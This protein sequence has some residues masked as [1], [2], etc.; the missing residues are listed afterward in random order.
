MK[1][2]MDCRYF[3]VNGSKCGRSQRKPDY[4]RGHPPGAYLAQIERESLSEKDCGPDA[5]YFEIVPVA[6]AA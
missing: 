5:R 2:C 6:A 1:L 4:V 3:I